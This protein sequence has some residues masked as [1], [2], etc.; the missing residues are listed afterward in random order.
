VNGGEPA[1]EERQARALTRTLLLIALVVAVVGSLGAPLITSVATTLGV[2]LA[3]AQWTLTIALLT[4]AVAAPV[5]GRLGTGTRRRAVVPGT[6]GVVAAGSAATVLPLPLGV[7]LAGRV[8]PHLLR[9]MTAP[10]LLSAA[11]T[12]VLA[13][14]LLFATARGNLAGP[15]LAMSL[16]G[17][18]VGGFSAAMPAVILQVTPEQE[19]ASAMGVNQV[20]RSTGFSLGSTL[21]ALVLAAYTA[22]GAV[23]PASQGYATAVVAGAGVTALALVIGLTLLR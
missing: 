22:G 12:V 19:T 11:T 9:R 16:L 20:V 21:S 10:A 8:S 18:G 2:S 6:L 15:L 7:L 14:Y 5:L 1:P 23:F 3:A 13:A 17:L 4:G